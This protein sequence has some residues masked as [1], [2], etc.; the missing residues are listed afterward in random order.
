[1]RA[2]CSGGGGDGDE[3]GGG[4]GFQPFRGRKVK[5]CP[6][7][8]TAVVAVAPSVSEWLFGTVGAA[9]LFFC[10]RARVSLRQRRDASVLHAGKGAAA[11]ATH[12]FRTPDP[13]AL[14]A[15]HRGSG[16]GGG[17]PPRPL[18]PDK[19]LA[20]GVVGAEGSGCGSEAAFVARRGGIY[21]NAGERRAPP[22][23]RPPSS[24]SPWCRARIFKKAPAR[25]RR[26]CTVASYPANARE[27]G[28]GGESCALKLWAADRGQ[29][30][31]ASAGT[32]AYIIVGGGVLIGR[33]SE[34]FTRSLTPPL[35][36]YRY[37]RPVLR[38]Y[39][40]GRSDDDTRVH[41]YD[42]FSSFAQTKKNKPGPGYIL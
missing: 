24:S 18:Q 32:R 36:A 40:D 15:I 34:L 16:G 9:R 2:G 13:I 41:P 8:T 29:Q 31:H 7:Q 35:H 10:W 42:S 1:M 39:G 21:A 6:P 19:P 11:A 5:H 12:A 20:R 3:G 22:P 27:T 26:Y 17:S 30:C 28:S 38:S 4:Y 14:S 37:T 33:P 25:E 23:L